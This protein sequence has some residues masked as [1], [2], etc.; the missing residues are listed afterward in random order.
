[1]CHNHA[2]LHLFNAHK[3][4]EHLCCLCYLH[5]IIRRPSSSIRDCMAA[6]SIRKRFFLLCS[7]SSCKS[8]SSPPSVTQLCKLEMTN[9]SGL[10]I[11][12]NRETMSTTNF[13]TNPR[14]V[15]KYNLTRHNLCRNLCQKITLWI[16]PCRK[17]SIPTV[18]SIPLGP[19]PPTPS[20]P[21]A[22]TMPTGRLHSTKA[23]LSDGSEQLQP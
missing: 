20:R 19:W 23:D 11:D 14:P 13:H 17:S 6:Y 10:P 22:S 1:M 18:T 15:P 4:F 5:F 7:R 8:N 12:Q 9:R 2:H 21:P 3:T 16:F